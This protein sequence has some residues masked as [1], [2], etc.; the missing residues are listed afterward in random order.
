MKIE[1][2]EEEKQELVLII[3][4]GIRRLEDTLLLGGLCGERNP[5]KRETTTE[6]IETHKARLKLG[7]RIIQIIKGD[8]EDPAVASIYLMGFETM[9]N[10]MKTKGGLKIDK[11][12]D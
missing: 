3:H 9:L 6:G 10:M 8:K 12:V 2:N 7:S 1:L 5:N 4:Q 11:N